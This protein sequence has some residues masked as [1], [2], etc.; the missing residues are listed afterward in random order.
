MSFT[1]EDL[2]AINSAI[3]AGAM[4]VRFADGRAVT[5]QSLADML[6]IR[7]II[8]SELGLIGDD[9]GRTYRLATH[10]KGFE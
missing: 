3:A 1:T 4:H 5:Y 7:N 9:G 2:T 6:K 8:R 10:S